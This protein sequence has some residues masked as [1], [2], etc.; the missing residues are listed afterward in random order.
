MHPRLTRRLRATMATAAMVAGLVVAVGAAWAGTTTKAPVIA[1]V[2]GPDATPAALAAPA[3]RIISL[4]PHLTE[5]LFAAGAGA[6]VVGAR[7]WSDHPPAALEIPRIGDSHAFDIERIVGLRPDLVVTWDGNAPRH[8]A[9]EGRQV[10][11]GGEEG[12][13]RGRRAGKGREAGQVPLPRLLAKVEQRGGG[14][15][16]IERRQRRRVGAEPVP[17]GLNLAHG[18]ANLPERPS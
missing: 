5:L 18:F 6:Q 8:V 9:Q 2:A 1:P 3:R 15:V 16:G 11:D 4:A 10:E 7:A 12:G 13:K 14:I 17:A